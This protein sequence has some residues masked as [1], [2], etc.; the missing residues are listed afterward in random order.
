MPTEKDLTVI[1]RGS[2]ASPHYDPAC[3]SSGMLKKS[4]SI[5]RKERKDFTQ[6]TQRI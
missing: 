2:I 6:R 4:K 1:R 5:N 3:L